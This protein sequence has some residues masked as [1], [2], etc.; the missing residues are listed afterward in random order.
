MRPLRLIAWA[1][2]SHTD[3]HS[4]LPSHYFSFVCLCSWCFLY[5]V[6]HLLPFNYH[7]PQ[8]NSNS[9][10]LVIIPSR[11]LSP[12][13]PPGESLASC[14]TWPASVPWIPQRPPFSPGA[15]PLHAPGWQKLAEL[16]SSIIP[17]SPHPPGCGP[18]FLYPCFVSGRFSNN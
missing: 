1:F 14:L 4:P 15:L 16:A 11:N 7:I 8:F 2:W 13:Q 12:T 5:L 10:R 17:F 9:L 6:H 18:N 3:C